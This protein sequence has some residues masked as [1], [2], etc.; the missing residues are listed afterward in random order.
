MNDRYKEVVNSMSSLRK[1]AATSIIEA[2][3]EAKD[4]ILETEGN[5]DVYDKWAVFNQ[6]YL[7]LI[8]AGR[9]TE[10]EALKAKFLKENG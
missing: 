10:A 2:K 1:G 4:Q 9:E 3:K 7:K 5:T 6:R 8:K